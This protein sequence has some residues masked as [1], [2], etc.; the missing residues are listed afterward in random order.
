[1]R[2]FLSRETKG[3]PCLSARNR[4][5]CGVKLVLGVARY[6]RYFSLRAVHVSTIFLNTI[7]DTSFPK[8]NVFT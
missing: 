1:M 6:L 7:F 3:V 4:H 5:A 2:L 8:R